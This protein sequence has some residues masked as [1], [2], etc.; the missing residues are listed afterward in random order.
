MD[1]RVT[2]YLETISSPIKRA[3]VSSVLNKQYRTSRGVQTEAEIVLHYIDRGNA[4]LDYYSMTGKKR[5]GMRLP[6]K[7][8][9]DIGDGDNFNGISK[10]AAV[11]ANHLL[12]DR[13]DMAEMEARVDAEYKRE[14]DRAKPPKWSSGW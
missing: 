3:K 5:E 13:Y 8:T 4:V 14:I 11:F 1:N 12:G 9:W 7:P 10:T 2:E 6:K